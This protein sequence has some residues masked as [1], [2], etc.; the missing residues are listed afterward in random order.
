MRQRES[1][2][3]RS[4]TATVSLFMSQHVFAFTASRRRC[5][6]LN[7]GFFPWI[8]LRTR[9]SS[10]KYSI[11]ACCS[12]F[13]QPARHRRMNLIGL[14][15]RLQPE[16]ASSTITI[17]RISRVLPRFQWA[18]VATDDLAE[19]GGAGPRWGETPSSRSSRETID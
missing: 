17:L 2:S 14:I 4:P 12:R 13:I 15:R 7:R 18:R 16:G 19:T 6:S 8:S 10:D 11:T 9:I 3:P 1:F 5:A